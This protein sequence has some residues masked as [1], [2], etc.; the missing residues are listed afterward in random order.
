MTLAGSLD[1]LG[2][3]PTYH[4]AAESP[5]RENYAAL[6]KIACPTDG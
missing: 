6:G 1:P 4:N 5:H 2:V 3:H